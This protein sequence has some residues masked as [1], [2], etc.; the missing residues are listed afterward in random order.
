MFRRGLTISTTKM[1]FSLSGFL[2]LAISLFLNP[3]FSQSKAQESLSPGEEP[4][5]ESMTKT[6]APA[7]NEAATGEGVIWKDSNGNIYANSK[8][9]FI[10]QAKDD[11]SDVEY[12]EYKL[13]DARDHIKYKG[14]FTIS[15]EGPHRI[16]YRAVDRAGN[17]E[18]DRLYNVTIDNTGPAISV[19]PGK[20]FVDVDGKLFSAPGNTFTIRAI[21]NLAGIKTV[22]YGVNTAAL[23]AYGQN[24]TVQL[25]DG[26]SQL[27][28]YRAA[29]NLDNRTVGSLLVEV[30]SSKPVVEVKPSQ[31]L[32]KVDNTLYARRNT[33]FKVGATDAGSGIQTILVRIDG[34]QEWQTYQDVVYFD[35]EKEHTIEARAIDLVGNES[36][37][38]KSSFIVDDNPPMTELKTSV[39]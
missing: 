11:L 9:R 25:T 17:R 22:E 29:D 4:G 24:Q 31:P 23:G 27:I 33:G 13:D 21:D 30:D 35:T 10:L 3:V 39:E 28:Q 34:A 7:T 2:L 8:V 12:I 1:G 16:T 36:E 20:P 5:A 15:E 32:I 26:G 38:V 18:V 19:L 6:E 37:I 14:P